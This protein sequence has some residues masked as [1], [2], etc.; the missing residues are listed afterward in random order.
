M[1]AEVLH[2]AFSQSAAG[3]IKQA[4][5]SLG[6]PDR[7]I[8]LVDDLGVG[9]IDPVDPEVRCELLN[10]V[11]DIGVD[12]G[13]IDAVVA[14]WTQAMTTT[15]T[16]IAWFSRHCV[17]EYAGFLELVSRRVEPPLIIDVADISFLDRQGGPAPVLSLNAGYVSDEQIVAR[18]LFA[19]ARRMTEA[20]VHHARTSWR[21]LRQENAALRVLGPTGLASASITYFDELIVSFTDPFEWRRCARVIADALIA[22]SEPWV[23]TDDLLLWSRLCTLLDHGVLEGRGSMQDMHDTWVRQR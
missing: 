8:G 14:F 10:D 1:V 11:L 23:Q 15:A 7:V 16:P 3:S 21:Q 2:I 5:S 17:R 20:E 9:P 19:A 22:S 4:L 12:T 13:W 6:R 18:D